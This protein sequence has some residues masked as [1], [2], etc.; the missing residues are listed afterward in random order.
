MFPNWLQGKGL[1]PEWL[2]GDT[3]N[4]IVEPITGG[5][6]V[7]SLRRK[8]IRDDEISLQ[9]V[10]KCAILAITGINGGDRAGRYKMQVR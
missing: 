5:A 1:Y 10:F 8:I 2:L 3:S 4:T 7:S 9:V 6:V